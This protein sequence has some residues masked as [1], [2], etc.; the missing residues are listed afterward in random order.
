MTEKNIITVPDIEVHHP[1]E[2]QQETTVDPIRCLA[3]MKLA[4][5]VFAHKKVL[6]VALFS[7]R[8]APSIAMKYRQLRSVHLHSFVYVVE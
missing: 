1:Q 7:T 3:V 8:I 6:L 2:S 4:R 5:S